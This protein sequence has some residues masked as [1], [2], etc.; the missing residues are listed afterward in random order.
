MRLAAAQVPEPSRRAAP[1]AGEIDLWLLDRPYGQAPSDGLI[2]IVT[3]TERKQSRAF[4]RQAHRDAFLWSRAFQRLV[5]ASY[6]KA[7][8][9]SLRFDRT[10]E[11]CGGYHGKPR[12]ANETELDFNVSNAGGTVLVAVAG[13]T[14]R[15]GVDV[16]Q[17]TTAKAIGELRDIICSS[18]E[19]SKRGADEA[20]LL[21][22][23]VR[24]EALLKATGHG[25]AVSPATVT[26]ERAAP[27]RWRVAR[28]AH[29]P[30]ASNWT[31]VDTPLDAALVAAVAL[32]TPVRDV[33]LT[34]VVMR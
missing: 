11:R 23:W 30:S 12:L 24:K 32:S 31:V 33:S 28:A 21:C 26:L 8:P 10:C 29:L 3:E 14:G 15:V 19:A 34:T 20:A 6:S 2:A 5:L 13:G 7:S 4:V 1:L 25:L 9:A 18:E 22:Q 27:G 17:R 16:E